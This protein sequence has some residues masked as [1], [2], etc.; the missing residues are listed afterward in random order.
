MCLGAA[1]AAGGEPG[2]A[3]ALD[4]VVVTATREARPVR[5]VAGNVTVITREE[6]ERVSA[7]SLSDVFRYA[8]GIDAA[9]SGTRFGTEG[10]ILR[11][12]GGN[13]VAVELDGIPVSQQFAVGNFSNASRNLIDVGQVETVEILHGPASA[14][15][16]SAALGGVVAI[17]TPMPADLLAAG[18]RTGL[19]LSQGYSGS[20]DTWSARGAFAATGGPVSGLGMISYQNGHEPG[21]AAADGADRQDVETVSGL[22]KLAWALAGGDVLTGM[23]YRYDSTVDTDI[24]SVLGTGR[25][26]STTRLEGSDESRMDLVAAEYRFEGRVVDGGTLRAYLGKSSFDQDTV[27]ERAAA[28]RPVRIDRRFG[29]DQDTAGLA[30]DLRHAFG[31]GGR[32][33]RV[34]FGAEYTTSRIDELR[35]GSELGLADGLASDT[36]LGETF[37]VRDFPKSDTNEIGVYLQDEVV[38]GPVTAIAALRFDRYRL[39][40][41]PDAVYREDNPATVPVEV[42][43]EEFSPRL[44]V[45]VPMGDSLDLWA[46]Y[47]HG[48]RAPSFDEANIGL[49][50]PLFNIRAIPNPDLDPESSDGLEAGVRWRGPRARV[51]LSAFYTRYDDFIESKARLGID[52]ESGRIL[53]QSRNIGDARIWGAEARAQVAL[54]SWVPGLSVQGSAYWARGENRDTGEPLNSVGPPQAVLGATWVSPAAR[55]EVSLFGTFTLRHSDLDETAGALFE[56]PGHGVYDLFVAWRFTGDLVARLAIENLGDKTWWRWA[57]V[58]GMAP[59]EP[60]VALMSQPGRSVSL[61]LSKGF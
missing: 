11:G 30:A 47:A 44:G 14:L 4:P 28:A 53:F 7:T 54:S 2:D 41:K 39:D 19:A 23:A 16:G 33:H 37:P 13:R 35:H 1:A 31:W 36:V 34:G 25:F 20:D 56:A 24:T 17:R 38:V 48:F 55:A 15:Y 8:P 57:D 9:R 45:I 42:D 27:D 51:D 12:L 21:A 32:T 26:R 18:Q 3:V 29:Y 40:P 43:S 58:R 52:P 46:Q 6:L 10:V 49:D 60:V 5:E 22:V 50:I 61:N 59:D